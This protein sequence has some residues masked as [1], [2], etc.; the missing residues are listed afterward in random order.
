MLDDIHSKNHFQVTSKNKASI[1]D[2]KYLY[3]CDAKAPQ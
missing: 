2:C 1:F 3:I